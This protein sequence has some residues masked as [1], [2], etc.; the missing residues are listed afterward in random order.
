VV[1]THNT[2]FAQRMPRMLQMRDGLLEHDVRRPPPGPEA[3]A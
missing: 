2:V 1:V 3:M